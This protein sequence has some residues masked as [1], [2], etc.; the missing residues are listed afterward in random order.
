[1]GWVA[2]IV[3]LSLLS[4]NSAALRVGWLVTDTRAIADAKSLIEEENAVPPASTSMN[5]LAKDLD[6]IIGL[7]GSGVRSSLWCSKHLTDMISSVAELSPELSRMRS[8]RALQRMAKIELFRALMS[9][10]KEMEAR[11]VLLNMVSVD[12]MDLDEHERL[13]SR[14]SRVAIEVERLVKDKFQCLSQGITH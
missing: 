4:H 11:T 1:M 2:S 8:V 13:N 3:A 6:S 7:C 14:D 5:S 12:S 10:A 9:S